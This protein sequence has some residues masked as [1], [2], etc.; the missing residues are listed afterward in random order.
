MSKA[1]GC[2]EIAKH[3][4]STVVVKSWSNQTLIKSWSNQTLIMQQLLLLTEA[5][6]WG[7]VNS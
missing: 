4:D 1:V 7:L 2:K 3:S 5:L 6:A